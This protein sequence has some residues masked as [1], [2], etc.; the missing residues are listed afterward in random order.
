MTV[1]HGFQSAGEDVVEL[2]TLVPAEL[3]RCVL[4]LQRERSGDDKGF[5]GLVLE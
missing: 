4:L 1:D 2:M 5:D 3:D